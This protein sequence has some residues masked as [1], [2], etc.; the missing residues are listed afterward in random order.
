MLGAIGRAEEVR[1]VD[2]AGPAQV[3]ALAAVQAEGGQRALLKAQF[4]VVGQPV[5]QQ[6]VDQCTQT[7]EV[8][9]AG[10]QVPQLCLVEFADHD[11]ELAAASARAAADHERAAQLAV[12]PPQPCKLPGRRDD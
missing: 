9:A 6:K 1:I 11:G 2:E 7:A 5:T 4:Q 12:G 3:C 10:Q 8:G